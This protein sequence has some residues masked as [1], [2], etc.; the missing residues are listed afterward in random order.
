MLPFSQI[1]HP[2][3]WRF[4][5][6]FA[7]ITTLLAFFSQT[8]G[9]MGAILTAWCF[10]FFR[11]PVR[12]TPQREGLIISAADGKIVAIR[13]VVPPSEWEIGEEARIRISVFLNIFDVHINRIPISGRIRKVIYH[14]GKFFNASLTT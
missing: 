8:L 9:W 6:I 2:E 12:V 5:A 11:N 7:G 3:G 4:I 10:Y 13:E 1:I 14:P